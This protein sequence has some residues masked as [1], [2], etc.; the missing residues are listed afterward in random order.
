MMGRYGI[1]ELY[2][3]LF[4][5]WILLMLINGVLGSAILSLLTAGIV[6]WQLFR[7]FSKN[8]V[9][10]RKEN[11]V[12]LRLWNPVKNWFV[13]QRDRFRD[14]KTAR[15]RKC[16]HCKAICRLPNQKGKHTVV[17]PKCH[18]R[19]DVNIL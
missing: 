14:R 13:L 19:F 15:Y 16:R 18:E 8:T 17:C 9:G 11:A 12:F 7:F 2:F 5:L 1:D 6:F 4:G 10:R 3:G